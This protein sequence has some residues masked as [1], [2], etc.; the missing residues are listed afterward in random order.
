MEVENWE[1]GEDDDASDSDDPGDAL[2]RA[3]GYYTFTGERIL[4]SSHI[5]S[6][7]VPDDAPQTPRPYDYSKG[8]A[9]REGRNVFA[10]FDHELA[11]AEQG[12]H[13]FSTQLR[14]GQVKSYSRIRLAFSQHTCPS[15]TFLVT[16]NDAS[17][18]EVA[19]SI[20]CKEV[21]QPPP[22][23]KLARGFGRLEY[24]SP[25]DQV[26]KNLGDDNTSPPW[27]AKYLEKLCDDFNAL[28]PVRERQEQER[29]VTERRADQTK[30]T[31]TDPLSGRETVYLGGNT[32]KS[33]SLP[34]Q[35]QVDPMANVHLLQFD[36]CGAWSEN[37][38]LDV[39][40]KIT[41]QKLPDV[42]D[43]HD[44]NTGDQTYPPE[45]VRNIRFLRHI[46]RKVK[47]GRQVSV[48]LYWTFPGRAA[49]T[50]LRDEYIGG[51]LKHFL[52]A[53][54]AD[55]ANADGADVDDTNVDDANEP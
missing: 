14:K 45:T 1:D 18:I 28:A 52:D 33:P 16:V 9:T 12:T 10:F 34:P 42:D 43:S 35:P 25:M 53:A 2:G 24:V 44:A 39:V 32:D 11:N 21:E 27:P 38:D 23:P 17:G 41:M 20:P 50:E 49:Q 5:A 8:D 26:S 31:I 4:R 46:I 22:L 55:S 13:T 48:S 15:L 36:I 6:Q 3:D 19:V 29:A 37:L 51:A 40:Q 7:D 30:L 54:K 47:A